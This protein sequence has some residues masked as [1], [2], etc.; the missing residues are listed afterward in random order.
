MPFECLYNPIIEINALGNIKE[1]LANIIKTLKTTPTITVS[2]C[3][4]ISQL[5][6]GLGGFIVPKVQHISYNTG[7]HALPDIYTLAHGHCASLGIMCI[8]QAKHSCLCYN[9]YLIMLL[10]RKYLKRYYH[11]STYI[12]YR[13]LLRFSNCFCAYVCVCPTLKTINNQ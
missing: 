9:F 13:L 12:S 11:I 8:C 3:Y 10:Y 5:I 7:T 4:Y 1:M 6:L 2:V